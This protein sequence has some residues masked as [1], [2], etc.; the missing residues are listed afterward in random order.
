[1]PADSVSGARDYFPALTG[2]RGVAAGWVVLLHLWLMAEA[3]RIAPFGLDLTPLLACGFLGVDLFFVLSG[4]LL[5]LPFLAWAQGLRPMPDLR[6]FLKRRALRVLPAYY[7][8]LAILVLAG[9]L[10]SGAWPI[11]WRQLLAYLSMEFVFFEV[12]GLPLNGV[13]WS[14]PVE[15]NFYLVLPLLGFAFSRARWWL[16]ALGVLVAVVGFRLACYGWLLERRTA[17]LFSYPSIIQLPARLDEFVFGMLG[18]WFHLRGVRPSARTLHVLLVAGFVGVGLVIAV[19]HGRGD[20]FAQADAPWIFV[21]ATVIGAALA[22]VVYASA[23]RAW[24]AEKLFSGRVLAFLGTISYSLYLW[25]AVVFQV[26]QRS[27]LT[28]WRP[29]ANFATLALL[30]IPVV[31]LLSWL[32]YRATEHPFLVTAPAARWDARRPKT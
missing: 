2:L 18:A 7:V 19:I 32:S 21:H 22:L 9:W 5:G 26:A 4:F 31:L 6:R 27:G 16:V 11:D 12:V 28:H 29:V 24:L 20:I 13:W 17:G 30:L 1:M 23:E 14:L 3:P 15:W 25:H 8:Q 10:V